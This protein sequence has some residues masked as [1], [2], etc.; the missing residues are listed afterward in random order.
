MPLAPE[1]PT[2]KQTLKQNLE[3][4]LSQPNIEDNVDQVAEQ[5]AN[6]IADA[7]YQ[8]IL[9]ANATGVDTGGDGHTLTIT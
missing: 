4:I 8:F 2:Y 9:N 6:A 5:M 1:L 7:T 3:T